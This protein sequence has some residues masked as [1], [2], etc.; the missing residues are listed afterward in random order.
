[1]KKRIEEYLPKAIDIISKTGIANN[2]NEVDSKFNG[3]FSSLGAAMVL[4][5]IKPAL[6][7]YSNT[8]TAKE[9][10]RIL[11]AIYRLVIE[12]RDNVKETDL[13]HYYIEHENE[14][15]LKYKIIDAATALKLAIRTYKFKD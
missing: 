14:P 3:Y 11:K 5:G 9:R 12:D 10:V 13:L 1:M 2:S 6:A 8:K 4:S 15:M 7:F